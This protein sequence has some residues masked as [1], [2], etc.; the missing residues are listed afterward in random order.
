MYNANNN[1]HKINIQLQNEYDLELHQRYL[2]GGVYKYFI[3]LD[4]EE[5]HSGNINPKQRYGFNVY[6]SSPTHD[7]CVG[8]VSEFKLTNFL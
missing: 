7:A 6:G 4:G 1:N 5:I 8:T 3:I 2:S